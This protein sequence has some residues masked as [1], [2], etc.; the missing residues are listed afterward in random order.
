MGAG[1][2]TNLL[3]FIVWLL[4]FIFIS[5]EVA[6]FCAFFYILILPITVCI[7]DISVGEKFPTYSS[8]LHLTFL[9]VGHLASKPLHPSPS[10]WSSSTS[11]FP[12]GIKLGH[13]TFI[14]LYSSIVLYCIVLHCIYLKFQQILIQVREQVTNHRIYKCHSYSV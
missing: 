6:G 13:Y 11:V 8:V 5:F 1:M 7:P 10:Y 3:W 9:Y 4:I 12:K 2:G 14:L